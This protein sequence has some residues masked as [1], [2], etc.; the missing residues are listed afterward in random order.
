[1]YS[2]YHLSPLVRSYLFVGY[3]SDL[4][5]AILVRFI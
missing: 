3:L 4:C 2:Y 5:G 1:M